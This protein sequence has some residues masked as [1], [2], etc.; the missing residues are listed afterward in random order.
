L[1][2]KLTLF[3]LLFSVFASAQTNLLLNGGFEDVNTC[4]EYNSEC[5][6]EGWF[7]LKDVKAQM[8]AADSSNKLTGTN[9]FGLYFNWL[10]YTNFSPLIGSILPCTLQKGK[11]YRFAGMVAATLN[12]KLNFKIGICLGERFYVP[13]RPFAKNMQPDSISNLTPIPNTPYYKFEY[14]FIATGKEKYLTFGTYIEQ[15]TVVDKKK[16]LTGTQTVS[17]M[18]D[19]FSLIPLDKTEIACPALE[20]NTRAIYN[21]N[22]RHKEMDYSLYGKGEL[23]IVFNYSDSNF[24]TRHKEPEPIIIRDTLKLGDVF[25]DFNKANLKPVAV[26]MLASH[27]LN[28]KESTTIDSIYIEGHTDSIGSEKRNLELSQ[29]RCEAVKNWFLLN[30]ITTKEMLFIHPFGKSR[31]ITTNSTIQGRALNR[32]V[33][34]IIFRTNEKQQ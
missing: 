20:T 29:L 1:K 5:G 10:G 7:Y 26:N 22:Y 27:F 23:K 16:Q 18:L 33:E 15:D 12:A 9:T 32:R 34:L 2:K 13:N 8:L 14:S 25:F 24:I 31:P 30:S 21:Y 17:I 3:A 4:T 19:N 6:V 11:Q 28:N